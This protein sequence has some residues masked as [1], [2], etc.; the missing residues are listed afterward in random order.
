[1]VTESSE[2]V[3]A[4]YPEG[5]FQRIFWEE[6]QKAM[7]FRDSRSMKW[8]PLFVRWCLYL[9]H[10]SGKSYEMLRKSGCIRLP[11]QRTLREYTH[12]ISTRIGFSAEIH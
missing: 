7:A 12:Y 10:L 2:E 1:M 6:Q 3:K 8:H 9:R 11:S 5:S 4:A